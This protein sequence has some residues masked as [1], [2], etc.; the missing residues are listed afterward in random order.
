MIRG[1][2]MDNN[3]NINLNST[4]SLNSINNKSNQHRECFPYHIHKIQPQM[5]QR[6][7]SEAVEMTVTAVEMMVMMIP[8]K[9]STR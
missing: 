3:L 2:M 6:E 1:D 8:M 4:V 5:L 7:R 9:C